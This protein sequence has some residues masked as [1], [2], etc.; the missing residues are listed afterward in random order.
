MSLKEYLI[1]F[2][3]LNASE[4]EQLFTNAREYAQFGIKLDYP[5]SKLG[6]FWID[7]SEEP[8]IIRPPHGCLIQRIH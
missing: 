4:R 6:R 8:G 1:D 7:E 2:S 3:A 5:G